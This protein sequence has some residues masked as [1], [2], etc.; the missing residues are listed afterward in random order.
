MEQVSL[1]LRYVDSENVKQHKLKEMFLEFIPTNDVTGVGLSN[2]ILNAVKR[3]G[4]EYC[5]VVG[6]GYDGA[7][8]MSGHFQGAQAYVRKE[9]PLALYVHCSAHSL[10]LAIADSCSRPEIRNC[11]GIVQSVGTFFRNSAQRTAV[12]RDN[13]NQLSTLPPHHKKNLLAMCE[14]R[15]VHKH[16]AV[17]RFKEI[18]PAIMAALEELQAV[19]NKETSNQAV[20]LLNTLR[21]SNFVVCL[22][23][24]EKVMGYILPLSKQLQATNIDLAKAFSHVDTVLNALNILRSNAEDECTHICNAAKDLLE[25]NGGML[26]IP[27]IVGK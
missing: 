15:W 24:L 2:L 4:L 22:A 14:T 20:Q 13:I 21:T 18:Y 26:Q 25:E 7:A 1:C 19:H 3:N 9:C 11:L 6:Q 12:L 16:E 5:H 8:S 27:R 23:V 17:L 10:N